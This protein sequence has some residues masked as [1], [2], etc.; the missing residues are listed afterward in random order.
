MM[1]R[2]SV[3]PV[4]KVVSGLIVTTGMI[5]TDTSARAMMGTEIIDMITR[6]LI[7]TFLLSLPTKSLADGGLNFNRA[8]HRAHFS[9]GLA[10]TLVGSMLVRKLAPET[11]TRYAVLGGAM[12][13]LTP[14]IL[15]EV[16]GARLG[17]QSDGSD[18]LADVLGVGVGVGFYVV[19]E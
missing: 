12:I 8:D 10:L 5:T 15:W 1:M 14:L 13:A 17:R 4:P 2:L 19:L 11:E 9:A 18:I 6:I 16:A 3:S 7:L